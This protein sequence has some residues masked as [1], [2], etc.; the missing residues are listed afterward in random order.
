MVVQ[1]LQLQQGAV[2]QILPIITLKD[3]SVM[4]LPHTCELCR[5]KSNCFKHLTGVSWLAVLCRAMPCYDL[6]CRALPCTAVPCQDVPCRALPCPPCPAVPCRVMPCQAVPTVPSLQRCALTWG[7]VLRKAPRL[8]DQVR[9]IMYSYCLPRPTLC[10]LANSTLCNNNHPH[11]WI[12]RSSR[13]KRQ[14]NI[15]DKRCEKRQACWIR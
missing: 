3:A 5:R 7:R 9:H 10:Y 1:D 15:Q 13:K 6:N 8:L 14:E 4:M 2:A 11:V 12:N